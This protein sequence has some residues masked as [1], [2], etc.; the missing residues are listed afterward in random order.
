MSFSLAIPGSKLYVRG[1]FK[2]ASRLSESTQPSVKVEAALRIGAFSTTG[3]I[4]FYGE[5]NTTLWLQFI[6]MPPR[7]PGVELC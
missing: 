2:A 1:V 5:L 6:V 3:G 4:D 7:G